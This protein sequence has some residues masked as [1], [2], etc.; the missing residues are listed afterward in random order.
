MKVEVNIVIFAAVFIRQTDNS[1]NCFCKKKVPPH[2]TEPQISIMY[3][4][5]LIMLAVTVI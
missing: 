4:D 1:L 5:F 3:E 2:P